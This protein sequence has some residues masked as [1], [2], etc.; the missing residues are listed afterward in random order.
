MRVISPPLRTEWTQNYWPV[1]LIRRRLR[2]NA[3]LKRIF[4][5][6]LLKSPDVP[7]GS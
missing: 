2:V 3:G 6:R 7:A 1:G 5:G 4:N